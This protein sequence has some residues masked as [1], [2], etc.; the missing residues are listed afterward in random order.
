MSHKLPTIGIERVK[1]IAKNQVEATA[2]TAELL[3]DEELTELLEELV[4]EELDELLEGERPPT[5]P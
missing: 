2:A 1:V 3:L 5:M 4:V